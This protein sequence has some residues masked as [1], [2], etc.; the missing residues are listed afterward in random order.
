[1]LFRSLSSARQL[2]GTQM[3][4]FTRFIDLRPRLPASVRSPPAP[5]SFPRAQSH[6]IHPG[7][8][9]YDSAR[10][11]RRRM[12]L[13]RSVLVSGGMRGQ[14]RRDQPPDG[15]GSGRRDGPGSS[16]GGLLAGLAVPDADSGALDGVLN[17]A[18]RQVSPRSCIRSLQFLRHSSLAPA[19]RSATPTQR[20]M[21]HL[22]TESAPVRDQSSQRL[23]NPTACGKRPHV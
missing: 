20:P 17:E 18:K 23:P 8:V 10:S 9:D 3:G 22:A 5:S 12:V 1:M 16:S 6:R 2:W 11:R 7:R 15:R 13:S 21:I 4:I 14:W 19:V